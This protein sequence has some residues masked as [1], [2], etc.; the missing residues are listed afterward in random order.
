MIDGVVLRS[1][2]WEGPPPVEGD[3]VVLPDGDHAVIEWVDAGVGPGAWTL[4]C[5]RA[6]TIRWTPD[7]VGAGDLGPF[8]R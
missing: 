3:V 1:N 7:P 4:R 2:E 6:R 5:R 8:R